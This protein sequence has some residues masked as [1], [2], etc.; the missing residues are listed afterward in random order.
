MSE[1]LECQGPQVP[2]RQRL[3]KKW[4]HPPRRARSTPR[5]L[6]RSAQGQSPLC[7]NVSEPSTS[8]WRTERTSLWRSIRRADLNIALNNRGGRRWARRPTG[9]AHL[10]RIKVRHQGGPNSDPSRRRELNNNPFRKPSL[11]NKPLDFLLWRGL[12]NNTFL[13]QYARGCIR[14]CGYSAPCENH[15]SDGN[16]YGM[17]RPFHDPPC[18]FVS[19]GVSSISIP[20]G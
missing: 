13:E 6:C 8:G 16:N 10:E 2:C 19:Y 3:Q 9:R 11:N 18:L 5:G 15:R 20:L 4:E 7:H 1:Q 17:R 14:G 12:N